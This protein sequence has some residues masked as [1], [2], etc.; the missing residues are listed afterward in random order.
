MTLPAITVVTIFL[1][2]APFLESSIRSVLDQTREGWELLLVDDGSTDGSTEIALSWAAR[3]PRIRYLD[4]PGHVNLGTARSR[5]AG[6]AA[7]RGHRLAF[8]DADDVWEPVTLEVLSR[9]L[10]R[11]PGAALIMGATRYWYSWDPTARE[12]DRT[13]KVGVPPGRYRPPAL[14]RRL[15]PLGRGT[16]PTVSSLLVERAAVEAV[17]GFAERFSGM[18]EDQSLLIRLYLTVDVVVTEHVCDRYRQR[19]GSVRATS[20][21]TDYLEVRAAF[22]EW[23]REEFAS[24]AHRPW[25]VRLRLLRVIV[26]QRAPWLRKVARI[27][28]RL[29]RGARGLR[30][31]QTDRR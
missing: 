23:F 21:R 3:D 1:D 20:R 19:V 9:E 25:P 27:L 5:N 12:P 24:Y 17:G 18:Y 22:I 16:S 28:R 8:L 14:A 30:R 29:A 31:W 4:H 11:Q 6:V 26:P 10:D 15:Y 7:A 13:V 2:A